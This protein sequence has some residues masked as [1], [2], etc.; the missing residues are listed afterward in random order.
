MKRT[1][2]LK[3]RTFCR[4]NERFENKR[5]KS[6][7]IAYT[8]RRFKNHLLRQIG[9]LRTKRGFSERMIKNRTNHVQHSAI[10]ESS[11]PFFRKKRTF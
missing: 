2:L 10:Q 8:A 1:L 7:R 4:P 3:T 9:T 6:D 5:A 11:T